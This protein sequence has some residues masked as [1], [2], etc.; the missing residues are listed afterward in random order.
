MGRSLWT[1]DSF[2][3]LSLYLDQQIEYENT[4]C[5]HHQQNQNLCPSPGVIDDGVQPLKKALCGDGHDI[6]DDSHPFAR[7][8]LRVVRLVRR[9]GHHHHGHGVTQSLKEAV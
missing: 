3:T 8:F 7:H 9:E 4:T 1:A 2:C 6:Q 5:K